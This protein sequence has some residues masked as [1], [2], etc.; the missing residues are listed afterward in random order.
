LKIQHQTKIVAA[1]FIAALF[2]LPACATAEDPTAI[3]EKP[4]AE[5]TIKA[6]NDV[7]AKVNSSEIKASELQEAIDSVAAQNPQLASQLGN[8]TGSETQMGELRKNILDQLIATELLLQEGKKLKIEDMD[9]QVDGEYQKLKASF[10]KEE[11]F[12]S[13]LTR[14]NATEK[15][16]HEKIRQGLQIQN[17]IEEKIKKNIS[18]PEDE[19]KS[20]YEENKVK[21]PILKPESVKASHILIQVNKDA[22]EAG[23]KKALKKIEDLLKRAKKGEDFAQMAKE[24]S[25]DPSAAQNGGDLGYFTHGQMVPE[26]DKAAFALKPGEISDIVQSSFG[27]HII[28]CEDKK[29]EQTIPYEEIESQISQYLEGRA[30]QTK[31]SEYVESLKKTARIEVLLK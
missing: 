18:I 24:N 11:D 2:I 28:K 30:L 22:D 23:E 26:F 3:P 7:V 10:P 25:E 8:M 13:M 6:E 16:V 15:E 31:L 14:Q 19:V 21:P 17:L 27:Y 29:A 1:F 4:L 20:F 5:E 9:Q 12:Q